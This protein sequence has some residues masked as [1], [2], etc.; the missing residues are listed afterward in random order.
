MQSEVGLTDSVRQRDPNYIIIKR[1]IPEPDQE[2]LF[3]H[4]RLLKEKNQ[5]AETDYGYGCGRN[6]MLFVRKRSSGRKDS[7]TRPWMFGDNHPASSPTSDN[8]YAFPEISFERNRPSVHRNQRL[9][10][11]SS[12]ATVT[13]TD[14]ETSS[15]EDERDESAKA[16]SR[17]EA[18][19][20]AAV[21]ELLAKYT[22]LF[23]MA[24]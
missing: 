12:S 8:E 16:I 11:E 9:P 22:T 23:E 20:M 17:D 6:D 18:E 5:L 2:I 4:T 1:W 7:F 13:L 3:E 10:S 19:G 14:G 21:N 24:A 15:S